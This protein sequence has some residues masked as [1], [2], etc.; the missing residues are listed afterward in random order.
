MRFCL[1]ALLCL[2][3]TISCAPLNLKPTNLDLGYL[4]QDNTENLDTKTVIRNGVASTVHVRVTNHKDR[5]SYGTGVIIDSQAGFIITAAHVIRRAKKVEVT[6]LELNRDDEVKRV[7]TINAEV[8]AVDRATDSAVLMVSRKHKLPPAMLIY[9]DQEVH[10]GQPVIHFGKT[11]EI[12]LGR[13]I[14]IQ[15]YNRQRGRTGNCLRIKID[16]DF[17]DSGAPV[18][19]LKTGRLVGIVTSM[20]IN[21]KNIT[22]ATPIHR[23]LKVFQGALVSN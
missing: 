23:V 20:L 17:G 10:F 11:S 19:D 8:L 5:V 14:R 12:S 9:R 2:S 22:F 15:N 1:L 21:R 6:L 13:V 7:K 18:V 16:S 3:F 4:Y